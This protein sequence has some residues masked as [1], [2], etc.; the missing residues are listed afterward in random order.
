MIMFTIILFAVASDFSRRDWGKSL[1]HLPVFTIDE[2]EN[3]R[4]CGKTP[5]S[6]IIK[7][8]HRGKKKEERYI[9]FGSISTHHDINS[10]F[11]KAKCKEMFMLS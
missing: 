9:S 11:I 7:T 10:F 3:H 2:I 1:T 5:E 8:L 6:A 4:K